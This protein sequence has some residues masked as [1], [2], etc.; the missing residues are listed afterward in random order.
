ME[1]F[2]KSLARELAPYLI[3]ELRAANEGDEWIDQ[4]SP[5]AKRSLGRN[6]FCKAVQERLERDPND[7]HARIIGDRYLLTPVGLAEEMARANRAPAPSVAK[8]SAADPDAAGAE[9]VLRLLRG[10]E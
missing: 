6:R 8:A 1:S 5:R 4:R 2:L 3:A 9:R 10:G 7:P